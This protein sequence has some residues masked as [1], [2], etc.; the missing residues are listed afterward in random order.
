MS[1]NEKQLPLIPLSTPPLDSNTSQITEYSGSNPETTPAKAYTSL[2][3]NTPVSPSSKV[4]TIDISSS[5][6]GAQP[7]FEKLLLEPEVTDALPSDFVP[8]IEATHLAK[9]WGRCPDIHHYNVES[10]IHAG[11]SGMVFRVTDARNEQKR[12]LKVARA[13]LLSLDK[14]ATALATS[15][16]PVSTAELRALEIVSHPNVVRL[17]DAL[18]VDGRVFAVATTYVDNPRPLDSFLRATLDKDPKLGIHRLSAER[19][20]GACIFLAMR[21]SEIASALAHMHDLS[22]YHFDVKP[23]NILIGGE[24]AAVLTDLGACVHSSDLKD[25]E[26]VR[27]H[28]SWIYAHP[29]LTSIS[30]DP[31]N[32]SGG[33]L[34]S[35]ALVD[36]RKGLARFDLHA[37]GKTMLESLGMLERVFGERCYASYG[38]RFLHVVAALL[39]DGRNRASQGHGQRGNLE[40][41]RYFASDLALDYPAEVFAAH[42]IT[43]AREL[44]DRLG[45]LYSAG[46]QWNFDIPELDRWQ[47]KAINLAS[48]G[49]APYTDRV[50]RIVEHPAFSRL[51][52]ESQLGWVKE[53]YPEATHTR[54]SHCLGVFAALS[55]YYS[56]LLDD[57]EVPTAR[58]LADSTDF[59]HALLAGLLHDI[60]QTSFGHDF[61][62]AALNSFGHKRFVERLLDEEYWGLPTLR[63]TIETAWPKLDLGRVLAI[64]GAAAERNSSWSGTAGE[65]P[66]RPIDGIAVDAIDGP[67]DADKLDYVHRDS[68]NCGVSYGLAVDRVRFVQSLTVAPV[69]GLKGQ[70]ALGLAYKAKGRP[71]IESLLLARYQLYGS[72]YWHHAFRCIQAMFVHAVAATLGR[73]EGERVVLRGIGVAPST[74]EHMFYH[75]V[76]CRKPWSRVRVEV[77]VKDRK[78]PPDFFDKEPPIGAISRE[79]ALDLLWRCADDDMRGLI[80]AL[81]KRALFRRVFEVRVGALGKRADYDKVRAAFSPNARVEK[82]GRIQTALFD[83]IQAKIRQS[84]PRASQTE[85]AA[86]VR[87][88]ELVGLTGPLV[89]VDFPTRGVPSEPNVPREVSDP[90]RKYFVME[91]GG[92]ETQ[93]DDVFYLVRQL[94]ARMATVRVFAAP[95]LHDLVTRYLGPSEV[96]ACVEEMVP[97]LGRRR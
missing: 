72:V 69:Q 53:V 7:D 26:E 47:P 78:L 52:E 51:K 73:L 62:S 9:L 91:Q 41:G 5:K 48:G 46:R 82:A 24:Q 87:Y 96:R 10:F 64:L 2:V 30:N 28:F 39:L 97:G 12:A 60:G 56:A 55:E 74:I 11:G 27:V 92:G 79:P 23:A 42:R 80:E 66:L 43:T 45:R 6:A 68:T 33:G 3:G 21:L 18:Q 83:A 19:V 75:R 8:A 31:A 1:D 34:K 16:S 44:S 36:P 17:F 40:H 84:D 90:E 57:P 88:E 67:L 13:R 94:Q 54:W 22:V 86:R 93:D 20:N 76:V 77:S 50:K 85:A 25:K 35:T 58:V 14:S 63:M 32:I 49:F 15:L 89:V 4:N 29:E 37:F 38:Y 65:S 95:R 59:E 61:E 71:A 70:W 81:A